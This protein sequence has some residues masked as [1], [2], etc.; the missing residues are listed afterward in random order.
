MANSYF[1]FKQFT[2]QQD[3]CAMK[4]TTDA[5]LFGAWCAQELSQQQPPAKTVLDI[6]TG[7]GLLALMVL[8]KH[9]AII[10]AVEI[11]AHAAAQASENIAA[12]PWHKTITVH[13]ADILTMLILQSYDAVISNPPFYQNDWQSPDSRRNTAHH[14]RQLTWTA[15]IPCVKK[16]LHATG[17]FFLL[18][19]YK[20]RNE[21]IRLLQQEGLF[22][23]KEVQVHQTENHE[24]FRMMLKGGHVQQTCDVTT[25]TITN[26]NQQYTKEATA[27]LQD[28]YL[29]L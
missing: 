27:L 8:Q 19:P 16:A 14:S 13:R 21:G 28:Y 25:L 4:V 2:I 11:D 12:S 7:T 22:V 20:R 15:L 10:D 9:T 3:A 18:L 24:P 29:Y 23:H 26:K 1:Q 5:C 17:S 6:G